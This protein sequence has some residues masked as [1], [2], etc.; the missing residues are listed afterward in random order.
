MNKIYDVAIIGGGPAGLTAGI[1]ASRAR[2]KAILIE[3]ALCG[4]QILI[5]DRIENYPGFPEGISGPDLAD[6]MKK[7][8][9]RFGL[10]FKTADVISIALKK[11]DASAFSVNIGEKEDLKALSII[12]ASGAIWNSLGIP[13]EAEFTG[14]GVSYCATCDGPL[15]RNKE[16]VVVGGGDTALEDGMF[17]AKFANKV[18]IVHRRDRLRATKILQERALANKKI[19][20]CLDSTATEIVGQGTVK[21]V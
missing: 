10:E 13:G 17:L 4:G 7:Q 19:S 12:I 21:G 16:V 11:D 18:T 1:Y 15:F 6:W 20:F 9:E 8:A 2:L 5:T 14:K 3:K